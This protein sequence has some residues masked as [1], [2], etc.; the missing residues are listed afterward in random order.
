VPGLTPREKWYAVGFLGAAIPLFLAGIY[1]GWSVLPNIVRLMAIFTPEEDAF[2]LTA[3]SYLDL[4]VKLL[5]AIGVG[6]IMPVLLVLLNFIGVIQ[7]RTILKG[8][9]I[10]ILCIMVFAGIATP[11]ADLMSMFLLA[12]PI[13]VLYFLAAGIALWHDRIVGKRR[14]RELA[15]YDLDDAE[16]A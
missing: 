15:A 10:A 4:S 14:S 11:A 5:L 12:A 8:W 2:Q 6:F 3:R 13:A 9:R 16:P 1:A 7:G